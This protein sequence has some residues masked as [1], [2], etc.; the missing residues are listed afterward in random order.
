MNSTA[1]IIVETGEPEKLIDCF[2]PEIKKGDR[3]KFDIKENER[4]VVFEV[5]AKDST[6]LRATLNSISK[7]LIVYEK[8]NEVKDEQGN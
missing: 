1:E 5:S 2:K 6:A 7:L 3:S 8:I 4:S